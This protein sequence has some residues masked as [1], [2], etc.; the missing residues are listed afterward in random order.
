MTE[1]RRVDNG[2][3]AV[4]ERQIKIAADVLEGR[5]SIDYGIAA[6]ASARETGPCVDQDIPLIVGTSPCK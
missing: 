4:P 3:P 2:E 1:R 6:P 5:K